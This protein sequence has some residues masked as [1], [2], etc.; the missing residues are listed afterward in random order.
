MTLQSTTTRQIFAVLGM[1]RSGTSAVVGMLE[2]QGIGLGQVWREI[3]D[4]PRGSLED[5]KIFALH[6]KLL[7]QNNGSWWNPPT[8]PIHF[9]RRQLR[10][11]DK[12]LSK[13]PGR[14]IAVKDPRLLV[15]RAFWGDID[16]MRI[17]VIR[18]PV[19][20]RRSLQART[21][22]FPEPYPS[23]LM[24]SGTDFGASTT[25]RYLKNLGGSRFL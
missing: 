1:H 23:Y 15:L 24:R 25:V 11:R 5:P 6:E 4:Q 17:G 18:N 3:A 20:V 21:H 12:I 7:A 8:S 16:L 10:R 19:A 14:L 13:Y 22:L 2:R 9:T